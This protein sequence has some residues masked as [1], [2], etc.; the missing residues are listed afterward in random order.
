MKRY[1]K[2]SM[3]IVEMQNETV[4]AGSIEG[5][6]GNSYD[7]NEESYGRGGRGGR[8]DDDWE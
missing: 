3:Q 5:K 7:P 6:L 2:P 4:L 1:T 8:G